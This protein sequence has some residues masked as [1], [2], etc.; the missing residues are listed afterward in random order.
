MQT[1]HSISCLVR[2]KSMEVKFEKCAV[3]DGVWC[4]SLWFPKWNAQLRIIHI[5]NVETMDWI[6]F[7]II[8]FLSSYEVVVSKNT[9]I[10]THTRTDHFDI[11]HKH[12]RAFRGVTQ[13]LH[14]KKI[15]QP[16]I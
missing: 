6:N 4:V 12:P 16:I 7:F 13:N 9:Y 2:S 15:K 3:S 14:M 11:S 1:M 5:R 10:H 8:S